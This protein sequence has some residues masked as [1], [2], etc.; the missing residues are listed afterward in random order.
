[1][2]K[3]E[4]MALAYT[5]AEA[6]EWAREHL[7]GLEAV[8]FP[9]FTPDLRELDEE[10]IRY[11]VNHLIANGFTYAMVAPEACG[12]TFAERKR[13]VEIVCDEASGRIS[14]SVAVMQDTVEEDIEML[15]HI[16]RVGGDFAR[17][18]HPIQYYP[19][20]VEDVFGMYKHM[21]DA[22]NL[23]IV[24]YANRLH[25]RK[26]HP[27][28]FPPEL[29]PWIADIPNVVG[30]EIGGGNSLP[31]TA[32]YFELCADKILVN[33]PVPDRWFV[34]V[35]KY[36]QQWAGAGPFYTSQTPE[37]PRMV[38]MFNLLLKGEVN[39]ALDVWWELA[40]LRENSPGLADSYF[41]TGIVTATSDKYAHWCNGGNGG[42]VRQPTGRLH[43][44]Q[45][46]RI[47]KGLM[48]VGLTP[49]E[50]EEEFY[51]GRV[52]YAKGARLQY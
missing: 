34:T 9:S 8:I 37:K 38:N 19:R 51:V 18:G 25:T 2:G 41:D 29:L 30:A 48:A 7:R 6:K 13:L 50:P 16:E 12:M 32:M 44:Y 24:F 39:K 36:G 17:L 10:G 1:V 47:R 4:R 26:L 52:N 43:D 31:T 35:P 42:S 28:Y 5:K 21:C 46:E 14:T 49:R 22:T 27:S 23:A 20:S 33:D 3:E 11:D 40:P 15:R 45:K